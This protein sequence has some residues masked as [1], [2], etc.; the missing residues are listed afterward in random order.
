MVD[1]QSELP[2]EKE[3][4][5]TRGQAIKS[6]FMKEL[7]QEEKTTTSANASRKASLISS[8]VRNNSDE[9]AV[10]VE[11]GGPVGFQG[12]LPSA[13]ATPGSAKKRKGKK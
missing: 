1:I 13:P 3:W 11:G 12:D 9:D 7:D 2:A 8:P 6:D 10:L 5:N 4:W